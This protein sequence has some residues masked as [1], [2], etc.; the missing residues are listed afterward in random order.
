MKPVALARALPGA[1]LSAAV[2]AGGCGPENLQLPETPNLD[3]LAQ[4][5]E[6]PTAPIDPN[7]LD[8][9]IADTTAR[10]ADLHLEWLPDVIANFLTILR[11]KADDSGLSDNPNTPPDNSRPRIDA[12][13]RLARNCSGWPDMPPSET[14]PAGVPPNGTLDGTAVISDSQLRRT[15]QIDGTSCRALVEPSNRIAQALLPSLDVFLNGSLDVLFYGQLP[16]TVQ[17]TQILVQISGEFGT[18]QMTVNGTFDFQLF[19]PQVNF[20][21]PRP[22]GYIIA[23][24]SPAG[25]TLRGTNATYACDVALVSCHPIS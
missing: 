10:L 1:L 17:Q 18:A 23:S 15:M 21:V 9:V 24:I 13:I 6:M 8:Q 7:Q 22:D 2:A 4:A 16:R 12:V 5:Y 11:Q 19:Y 14:A 20:R 3:M 25:V